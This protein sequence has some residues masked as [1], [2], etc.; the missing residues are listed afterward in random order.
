MLK[1]HHGQAKFSFSKEL[2]AASE[3]T[4]TVL[5]MQKKYSL[6]GLFGLGNRGK[7]VTDLLKKNTDMMVGAFRMVGHITNK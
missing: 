6:L 7:V 3:M 5:R 2:D 4:D 1:K